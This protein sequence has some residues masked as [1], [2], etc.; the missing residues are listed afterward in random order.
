MRKAIRKI[1]FAIAFAVFILYSTLTYYSFNL[2]DSYYCDDDSDMK[3]SLN[4][5]LK[6]TTQPAHDRTTP[7]DKL[8][9]D[10]SQARLMLMN[11]IPIKTV[12]VHKIDVPMLAPSGKPF[13]IK[14]IM[15]GVMV[16][17]TGTVIC[18]GKHF[19][20]AVDAG[21]KK[22]DVIKA[23]NDKPVY[24][25]NDIENIISELSDK[26]ITLS[27]TRDN[28]ELQINITAVRSDDD[29]KYK[30]GLWVR[31]SSAGIGT[32]TYF[33]E[34]NGTFGGLGHPVCD[35]DTGQILPL[36]SGE[37]MH[38]S[39][40]GVKKGVSGV[41]GELQ[42][43][44]SDLMSCGLLMINNRYGVFGTIS[45]DFSEYEAVP[46]ALKQEIKT[47][48]AYIY[49]TI[50]G[51]E[52]ETYDIEIEE[53]NYNTDNSSKNM[54][55]RITDKDLLEKSGGI[56]QGMS[57]SPIIQNGKLVGAITHVFVNDPS[58]GYGIFCE[59]MYE[60]SSTM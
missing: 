20:P 25:N 33:D 32:V 39:I 53:I 6:I 3:F 29:G 28:K 48:S 40:S 12:E 50:D 51:T 11:I 42:G 14:L 9:H 8:T 1:T 17:K 60:M 7:V 30:L 26:E 15:D 21:I 55:I 56:V 58:R 31:D 2:P 19:S 4:T 16:I 49:S 59:N 45:S 47:G 5:I 35:S 18:D 36:S 38:V 24:S 54:V 46:M 52:P 10:T 27:V 13:G 23:I 37:V 43:Y 44:F 41:P 57:G 22:G 34:T